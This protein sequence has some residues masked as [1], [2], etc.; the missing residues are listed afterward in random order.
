MF[1]Y[2]ESLLITH[3]EIAAEWSEKNYPLKP[4]D[5]TAGCHERVWWKGKCGHEWKTGIGNRTFRNTGCPYCTTRAVLKGFNDFATLHPEFL[6]EW[7]DKNGDVK[8]DQFREYS[9]KKVWWKCKNG[10]E[11][12]AS[13]NSRLKGNGCR[14]CGNQIVLKGFNDLESK[15]PDLAKEWSDKNLPLTP[16]AVLWR[17]HKSYW[18]K[19]S[20]CGNE[21]ENYLSH[22][23]D[24]GY[25]CPYCKGFKVAA[26]FNDLSTTD[27]EIVKDWDYESNGSLL[28]DTLFR[29]SLRFVKWKCANGH[30]YGMKV[31]D[32]TVKSKGC[33]ICDMTFKASFSEL[34]ILLLAKREGIHYEIGS[35]VSELFLPDLK[36]AF[37]TE[38]VS[39]EKQKEQR[40]RRSA[41]KKEGITLRILPRAEDLKA[42]SESVRRLF[43]QNRVN[44]TGKIEDDILTLKKDFYGKDYRDTPY[45]GGGA[46]KDVP[47]LIRNHSKKVPIPLPETDPVLCEEWSEKNFPFKPGDEHRESEDKVWWKC[48]KCGSEWKTMIRTRAA[49]KKG[50][51]VCAGKYIVVGINDFA[52][53]DPD[54]CKEWS[55]KNKDVRPEQFRHWSEVKIWWRCDKGHEWKTSINTRVHGGMCPIC[56]REPVIRDVNDLATTNPEVIKLWSDK[57]GEL[58]PSDIRAT[59]KKQVWWICQQCSF[60]YQAQPRTVIK[61]L[62]QGCIRC[63]S[64]IGK[65]WKGLMT[66]EERIKEEYR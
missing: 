58:K 49:L 63:Q 46:F 44:I 10:H 38:C 19:C 6:S 54:L 47:G 66:D 23:I 5:V 11:W 29:T 14:I 35:E 51:P 52:T 21:F 16:D 32:R 53:T 8:P 17:K 42:A 28:P 36:L 15:R 50:C 65:K 3:P 33:V 43:R 26:G 7:S 39:I 13:C 48:R 45:E 37:E 12:Q 40:K 9:N 1:F 57:N 4:S 62:G 34:L 2:D 18:W 30:S 55:P 60:E 56:A 59:Y 20:K 41:L 24:Y 61:K 64:T 27:P 22:R 25:G 31:A